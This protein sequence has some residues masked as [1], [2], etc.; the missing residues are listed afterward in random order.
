MSSQ[1]MTSKRFEAICPPAPCANRLAKFEPS[2]G[3]SSISHWLSVH[4]TVDGRTSGKTCLKRS[5]DSIVQ[6]IARLKS[7]AWSDVFDIKPMRRCGN[8]AISQPIVQVSP[9]VVL[10]DP[11]GSSTVPYTH[12]TPP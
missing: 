7:V 8:W 4:L 1:R 9:H 11:R 3:L 5:L 2:H 6:R 10:A 12:L